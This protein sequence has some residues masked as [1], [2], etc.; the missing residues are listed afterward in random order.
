MPTLNL[1]LDAPL[2][3]CSQREAILQG[4]ARCGGYVTYAARYI[5]WIAVE[6]PLDRADRLQDVPGVKQLEV[7]NEC[8]YCVAGVADIEQDTAW[9]SEFVGAV[10]ARGI[11]QGAGATVAILDTGIAAHPEF[12]GANIMVGRSMV[13]GQGY[14]DEHGH[15][16]ANTGIIVAK[17][18]VLRGIASA[19]RVL[20]VKVLSRNGAGL[21]SW[22]AGGIEQAIDANCDVVLMAMGGDSRSGMLEDALMALARTGAVAVVPSGNDGQSV[23]DFPGSSAFAITASA[24]DKNGRVPPWSASAPWPEGPDVA[25]PGVRI[26]VPSLNGGYAL[27]S[28]T[29]MAASI[30][31]GCLVLAYANDRSLRGFRDTTATGHTVVV[32][33]RRRLQLSST[34]LSASPTQVGYGLLNV[35]RLLAIRS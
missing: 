28:G 33:L 1:K 9:P 6:M 18:P 29:S 26:P 12:H 2:A 21:W 27:M 34:P 16:T 19:A 13:P 24:V 11:T 4:I 25:A 3:L 17:G 15:G 14:Q 32:E 7:D 22:V 20:V 23:L 8:A 31:A 30:A 35:P 5:P 10:E